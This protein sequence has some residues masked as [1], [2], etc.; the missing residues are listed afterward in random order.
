MAMNVWKGFCVG[1]SICGLLAFAAIAEEEKTS[2]QAAT[3]PTADEQ[4]EESA[5]S[6]GLVT[7]KDH[8]I[9]PH[10]KCDYFHQRA[11][12][13]NEPKWWERYRNCESG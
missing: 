9:I 2:P 10:G 4:A 3:P 7:Y 6:G 12:D 1:A 5:T 11:L 13:S 8:A